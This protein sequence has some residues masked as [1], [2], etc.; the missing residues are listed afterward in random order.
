VRSIGNIG[1]RYNMGIAVT[2]NVNPL[3]WWTAGFFT[4]LY[5]NRYDGQINGE[6]FKARALTLSLSLNNQFRLAA[7][8]AAEV[9]G[10]YISQSRDEGQAIVL[11][12]GQLSLGISKQVLNNRAVI[13]MNVRDIF[14]TLNPREIQDFQDIQSTL[15]ITRDSRVANIAFVWKFGTAQ[16][17]RSGSTGAPEEKDRI[18]LN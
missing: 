12:A 7:G 2:A 14:Y 1:T 16:K 13:K 6:P 11:P 4:N 10:N 17:S 9:S 18:K 3:P 5:Q 8:W 15:R